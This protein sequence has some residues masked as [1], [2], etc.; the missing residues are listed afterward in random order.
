[1]LNLS[2]ME[3]SILQL[4]QSYTGNSEIRELP[5]SMVLR[6]LETSRCLPSLPEDGCWDQSIDISPLK[7]GSM[8]KDFKISRREKV[9]GEQKGDCKIVTGLGSLECSFNIREVEASKRGM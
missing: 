8:E 7:R 5:C 1:M 2:S 3:T 9:G 4:A 6:C